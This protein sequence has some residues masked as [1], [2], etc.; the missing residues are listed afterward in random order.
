MYYDYILLIFKMNS[1][2]Y[3]VHRHTSGQFSSPNDEISELLVKDQLLTHQL[4]TNQSKYKV[5]CM[6]DIQVN[7]QLN[8]LFDDEKSNNK[9]YQKK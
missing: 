9:T 2:N 3:I 7:S 6:Y 4:L 8:Q 5:P 1:V